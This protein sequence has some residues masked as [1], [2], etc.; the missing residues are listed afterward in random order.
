[1][2]PWGI[3]GVLRREVTAPERNAHR[4]EV[5][6][7][8]HAQPR[9]EELLGG[10]GTNPPWIKC[11]DVHAARERQREA[12]NAY[13]RDAGIARQEVREILEELVLHRGIRVARGREP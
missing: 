8:D 2:G 7:T 3:G 12:R 13:V 1:A 9:R 4:C 6:G 11:Q 10:V 5:A